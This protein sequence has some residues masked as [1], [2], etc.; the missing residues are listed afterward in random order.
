MSTMDDAA[1][2][3]DIVSLKTDLT[4][5]RYDMIARRDEIKFVM[6]SQDPNL[7]PLKKVWVETM[8]LATRAAALF[9]GSGDI[10]GSLSTL[11]TLINGLRSAMQR[12]QALSKSAGKALERSYIVI[13]E[14][15]GK[16]YCF[17]VDMV[18][19]V[20]APKQFV[21]LPKMPYFTMGVIEHRKT[22]IPI[23]D[24]A[25][26]LG[27]THINGRRRLLLVRKNGDSVAL[28]VDNVRQIV[29]VLSGYF[30][31]PRA[32]EPLLKMVY[33]DGTS[34][35]DMLDPKLMLEAGLQKAFGYSRRINGPES[36]GP[37]SVPQPDSSK[38]SA[39]FEPLRP[40]LSTRE[41]RSAA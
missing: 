5:L 32:N 12:T 23:V 16:E 30:R 7:I 1:V 34:K 11:G 20:I 18:Q 19:E 26:I 29:P 3:H 9:E 14:L 37:P 24:P 27:V 21:T 36:S 35:I 31:L 28:L 17:H 8:Q 15:A 40:G 4:N 13:F 6:G 41:L 39:R 25:L 2:F 33:E 10:M 22:V 38:S